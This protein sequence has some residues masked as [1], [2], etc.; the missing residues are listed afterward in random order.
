MSFTEY[1]IEDYLEAFPGIIDPKFI[2]NDFIVYRQFIIGKNRIDLII[3]NKYL[4]DL[5]IIEI[6]KVA[7]KKKHFEQILEYY[8]CIRNDYPEYNISGYIIGLR[9]HVELNIHLKSYKWL[10]IKYL[11][12]DIPL[13]IKIC[14]GCKK[15]IDY[16]L[17]ECKYCFKRI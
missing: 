8:K 2:M 13:K 12:E 10:F 15:P 14:I 1:D 7:L 9:N 3:E 4:K 6:K 17:Y 16:N 11:N 5:S